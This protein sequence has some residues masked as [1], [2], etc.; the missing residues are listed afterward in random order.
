MLF[1]LSAWGTFRAEAYVLDFTTLLTNAFRAAGVSIPTGIIPPQTI[2]RNG[3]LSGSY[4]GG[5]GGGF[6]GGGGGSTFGGKIQNLISCDAPAGA[7]WFIVSGPVSGQLVW[8]P[9]TPVASPSDGKNT[10]G[11]ASGMVPCKK[12]KQ[13]YMGKRVTLIGVSQ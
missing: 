5:S 6:G 1:L 3:T 4:G 13:V 10:I 7:K 8:M 12:G 11:N 2:G 9:G